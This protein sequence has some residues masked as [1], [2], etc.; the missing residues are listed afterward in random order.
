MSSRLAD[1]G[2]ALAAVAWTFRYAT[3][4]SGY[5][6]DRVQLLADL[7]AQMDPAYESA[8]E[9]RLCPDIR[10]RVQAVL[11]TK[12]EGGFAVDVDSVGLRNDGKVL[13]RGALV[14]ANRHEWEVE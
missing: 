2:D 6:T 5:E 3:V 7:P 11:R 9:F 10:T 4:E 14:I 8:R 13:K 12:R 1:L